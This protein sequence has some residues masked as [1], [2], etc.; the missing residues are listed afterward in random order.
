[1]AIGDDLLG[2]TLMGVAANLTIPSRSYPAA[3]SVLALPQKAAKRFSAYEVRFTRESWPAGVDC[4]L[5]DGRVIPNTALQII[6]E[7]SLDGGSSWTL[8][9]GATFP[10]GDAFDGSGNLATESALL[11]DLSSLETSQLRARVI[12]LVPIT[13]AVALN[14]VEP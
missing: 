12:V 14:V 5:A 3:E 2:A 4:I 7:K 10:G 11:V 9:S 8:A 1:M 6:I 13:T